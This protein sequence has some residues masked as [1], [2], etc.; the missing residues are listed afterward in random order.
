MIAPESWLKTVVD[1]VNG[2]DVVFLGSG[3]AAYPELFTNT[4][5]DHRLHAGKL[6]Q[7]AVEILEERGVESLPSAVPRYIRPS[8]AEINFGAAPNHNPVDNLD[9]KATL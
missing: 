6:A 9:P 1:A 5:V 4:E 2:H 7:L 8:Q 3:V